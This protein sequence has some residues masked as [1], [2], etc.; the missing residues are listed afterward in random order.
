LWTQGNTIQEL[1]D[2]YKFRKQGAYEF[3]LTKGNERKYVIQPELKDI[4]RWIFS[5]PCERL[6][7]FNYELY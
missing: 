1:Y 5:I 3:V 4:A 2:W 7:E 6:D